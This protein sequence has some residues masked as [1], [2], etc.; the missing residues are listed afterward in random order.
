VVGMGVDPSLIDAAAK[1]SADSVRF[2]SR[3]EITSFGIETRGFYETPWLPYRD[4]LQRHYV[5]KSVTQAKGAN[6]TEYRTSMLQLTCV[7]GGPAI[8]LLY[9]RELSAN[10]IGVPTIV[11]VAAGEGELVLGYATAGTTEHRSVMTSWE[12]LRNE[13]A[14]P[15]IV[16][17]ETFTPPEAPGWSHVIK[18]STN[19]LWKAAEE[20]QKTCRPKLLDAPAAKRLYSPPP[21]IGGGQWPRQ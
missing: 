21:V 13:S 12:F 19:G 20:L 2:M 17:T 9:Q 11:R 15:S 7:G 18:V 16:V 14:V 3:D 8:A 5:L 4:H 1:I 10:E 6:G